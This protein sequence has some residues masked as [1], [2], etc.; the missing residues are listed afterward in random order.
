MADI[1]IWQK[2]GHFYFALTHCDIASLVLN[3]TRFEQPTTTFLLHQN[4]IADLDLATIK[5]ENSIVGLSGEALLVSFA[6][7][8]IVH[9]I[10]KG[11]E[12]TVALAA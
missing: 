11:I 12:N 8:G 9:L 4:C 10:F 6:A 3:L 5:A 1:S 7:E 2:T